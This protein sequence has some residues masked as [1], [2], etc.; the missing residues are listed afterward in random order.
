MSENSLVRRLLLNEKLIT[1]LLPMVN[2]DRCAS[3][4]QQK[5]AK[6]EKLLQCFPHENETLLAEWNDKVTDLW[7]QF[8]F[9]HNIKTD[10]KSSTVSIFES[11]ASANST[12]FLQLAQ[13]PAEKNN[14]QQ[15]P[16]L[17]DSCRNGEG[18]KKD[19]SN[20]QITSFYRENKENAVPADPMIIKLTCATPFPTGKNKK[21]RPNDENV[22][23][24]ATRELIII[25]ESIQ[26]LLLAQTVP[27][28]T[29]H[30][31][32]KKMQCILNGVP[33]R[34][35]QLHN[36]WSGK[37]A[38]HLSELSTE[39]LKQEGRN[40]CVVAEDS[41][42]RLITFSK[43]ENAFAHF[44]KVHSHYGLQSLLELTAKAF[45]L[46]KA[47][48]R[49]MSSFYDL[50]F[51]KLPPKLQSKIFGKSSR[52][53]SLIDLLTF[54]SF[55]VQVSRQKK[56]P[57]SLCFNCFQYGHYKKN[58]NNDKITERQLQESL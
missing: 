29:L 20:Q 12:N 5:L 13:L 53:K 28:G 38:T 33:K 41:D 27:L 37:I 3:L 30:R 58:C 2:A 31:Q 17:V 26:R 42:L 54:I 51:S 6:L 56:E 57:V 36:K 47:F 18:I 16:L 11:S 35:A 25:E 24:K 49:L 32:I 14:N 39:K 50:A 43:L 21:R 46:T 10:M 19:Q 1:A 22:A 4:F 52:S 34:I 15:P 44:D 40:Q 7:M 23:A 48:P 8:S 55:E 9:C 45:I